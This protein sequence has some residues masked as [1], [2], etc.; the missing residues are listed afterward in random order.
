MYSIM[1]FSFILSVSCLIT[2]SGCVTKPEP[3][4]SILRVRG[5]IV[6]AIDGFPLTGV[7]IWMQDNPGK[8]LWEECVWTILEST[9]TDSTGSYS[10]EIPF[11]YPPESF[12]IEMTVSKQGYLKRLIDVE[13]K[14]GIQT[15]NIRLVPNM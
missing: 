3:D 15:F 7:W 8:K 1:R 5:N 14:G 9:Y 4:L 2:V 6:D 13:C 12:L 10:I 11:P